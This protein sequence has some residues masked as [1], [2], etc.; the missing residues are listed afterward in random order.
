MCCKY[1][2]RLMV[3]RCEVRRRWSTA[4]VKVTR[5]R[6]NGSIVAKD[7]RRV[8]IEGL[9][10]L[11][12]YLWWLTHGDTDGHEDVEERTIVAD[13]VV[14]RRDTCLGWGYI[15]STLRGCFSG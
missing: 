15:W 11:R 8:L 4:E 9:E 7:E 10:K 14:D 6:A 13:V 1:V 5:V 12:D 3:C 2:F